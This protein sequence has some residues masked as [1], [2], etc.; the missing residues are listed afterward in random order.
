MSSEVEAA[1]IVRKLRPL[2]ATMAPLPPASAK[3][4]RGRGPRA[5]AS[6]WAG[7]GELEAEGE[8]MERGVGEGV[9]VTHRVQGPGEEEFDASR[10]WL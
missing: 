7:G 1:L 5:G 3:R 10:E 8:G 2:R 4:S 9:G 6:G